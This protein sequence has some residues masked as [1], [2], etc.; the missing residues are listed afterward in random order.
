MSIY[1]NKKVINLPFA[2]YYNM[3]IYEAGENGEIWAINLVQIFLKS[4]AKMKIYLRT[5]IKLMW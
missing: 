3:V 4:E 1:N 5:T 2:W